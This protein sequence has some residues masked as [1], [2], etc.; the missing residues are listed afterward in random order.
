MPGL[1]NGPGKENVLQSRRSGP[2]WFLTR[3]V[4]YLM[5][6]SVSICRPSRRLQS[7][8]Y[9]PA[10]CCRCPCEPPWGFTRFADARWKEHPAR[11]LRLRDFRGPLFRLQL[12]RASMAQRGS[13]RTRAKFRLFR[14]T[15]FFR[16]PKSVPLCA[17]FS[18]LLMISVF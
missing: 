5:F 11:S 1:R 9:R 6:W 2:I 13:P 12:K 18:A 15:E 17:V 3:T 10:I 14:L 4:D 8:E 16:P 7:R